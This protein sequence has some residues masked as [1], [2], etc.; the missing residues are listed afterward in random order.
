MRIGTGITLSLV[1]GILLG[2]TPAQA[3]TA[4]STVTLMH[5]AAVAEDLA[6]LDRY[7]AYDAIAKASLA[8]HW[9]DFTEQER[10]TF[11]KNFR[12]IVRHTYQKGLGGKSKKPLNIT[13]ESV[14]KNGKLVHTAVNMKD[15]K[16]AL[17]INYLMECDAKSCLLVD[18]ITDGSSLVKSWKRM[19]RRIVK[20]HGKSELLARIAKKAK[21]VTAD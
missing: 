10:T 2:A 8:K 19:F 16:T 18:V 20:K 6:A 3:E 4:R 13:G 14:T 21:T 11:L 9:H 1:F 12:Q 17:E 7:V 15:R 5:K